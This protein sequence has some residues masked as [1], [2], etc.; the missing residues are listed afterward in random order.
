MVECFHTAAAAWRFQLSPN[1]SSSWSE[2]R[3]VVWLAALPASLIATGCVC[4]GFWPIAPFCGAELLALAAGFYHNA[5]RQREYESLEL[6]EERLVLVRVGRHGREQWSWQRAFAVI[7]VR[8]ERPDEDFHLYL[9]CHGRELEFARGL[10]D[11][12]KRF[13]V[14]ELSALLR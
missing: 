11:D 13:L 12:D 5:H 14:R 8:S 7:V 3:R 4:L 9:R 2:C 10:N 1:C 6:S